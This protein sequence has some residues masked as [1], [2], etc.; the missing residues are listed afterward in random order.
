MAALKVYVDADVAPGGDGTVGDPYGSFNEAEAAEQQDLTDGGGDT[1]EF[2]CQGSAADTAV[3]D[4]NGW[5]TAAA[6]YILVTTD[7]SNRHDGTAGTGY[8]LIP[9]SNPASAVLTISEEYVRIIGIAISA[10]IYNRGSDY[11]L[12]SASPSG[13]CRI[14]FGYN[15]IHDGHNAGAG[16]NNA[17]RITFSGSATQVVNIYNTL[18][19]DLDTGGFIYTTNNANCTLNFY[20]VTVAN[21]GSDGFDRQFNGTGLV[22]LK[23]VYSGACGSADYNTGDTYNTVTTCYDS[24]AGGIA[25]ATAAHSTS[26]GCYFTNITDGSED[27]SIKTDSALKDNGTDTS[28]TGAPLD[29]TDD[30]VGETR[31]TWD[32]GAFEFPGAPPVSLLPKGSLSM[33]GVG[34]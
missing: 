11:D 14:D 10:P 12:V 7:I 18:V 17:M 1:F 4:I 2:N 22:I 25:G 3:V 20:S 5:T 19:F 31:S 29:F 32:V 24:D 9:S 6:N 26:A 21:C 30:I 13:A 15:L 16:G 33:M 34:I 8:R 23:N 28:G 27:Y